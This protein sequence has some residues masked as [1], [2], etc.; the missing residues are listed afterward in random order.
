M[1]MLVGLS[2]A[3]QTTN[4]NNRSLSLQESLEMALAHNLNIRVDRY[5]PQIAR[6]QL[7]AAYGIYDPVLS[8][9]ATVNFDKQPPTF[10]PK[11]LTQFK[12]THEQ[13]FTTNLA[14]QDAPYEETIDSVGAALAGVIPTGLTYNLFVRGDYEDARSFPI[15][16]VVFSQS[17]TGL[18]ILP[19]SNIPET[20]LFH[21]R[22]GV[23]LSQ[24]LL[25]DFLID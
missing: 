6:Y 20:N 13:N 5:A 1:G 16:A 2:A 14:N 11:K 24:P 4:E 21:P 10:D 19:S 18:V 3:A 23:A 8:L 22:I 15:P 9:S 25:K 12:P 17:V 7:N